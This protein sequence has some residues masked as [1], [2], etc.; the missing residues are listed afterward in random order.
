M[1]DLDRED[2]L[3]SSLLIKLLQGPIYND[4]RDLWNQLLSS[5]SSVNAYFSKLGLKLLLDEQQGFGLLRSLNNET[6]ADMETDHLPSLITRRS[7][8]YEMTLLFVLLREKLDDFDSNVRDDERPIIQE[9]EICS[10]LSPFFLERNNEVK[11]ISHFQ[12]MIQ[13][14]IDWGVLKKLK[15]DEQSYEIR[16]VLKALMDSSKLEEIKAQLIEYSQRLIKEN[17]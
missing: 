7:H 15:N 5:Q 10:L 17:G 4:Q 14:A 2:F 13:K 6:T 1:S 11:L 12:A 3:F 16:R 9:K 8:T